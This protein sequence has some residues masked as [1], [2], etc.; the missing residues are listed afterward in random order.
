MLCA[1][2]LRVDWLRR[3]SNLQS[4]SISASLCFSLWLATYN[5]ELHTE[6]LISY[7]DTAKICNSIKFNL[8][9]ENTGPPMTQ[10]I[11]FADAWT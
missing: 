2:E 6:K 10:Y 7:A 9:L 11:V 3:L 4:K 1:E 5:Y 8:D